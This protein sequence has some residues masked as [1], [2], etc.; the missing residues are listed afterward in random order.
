MI[1]AVMLWNEPNNN[2]HW[3]FESIPDGDLRRDDQAAARGGA[4]GEHRRGAGARRHIAHRPEV[5][6]RTCVARACSRRS[7]SSRCM[8]FR[9]IGTIG[10][11]ANGPRSCR[12]RPSP[13]CPLWVTEVGVSTFGAEEVQEFGLKR[14]AELLIARTAGFT[15]TACTTCRG[16]GPRR[17]VT[18]KPKGPP[19]TGISTWACLREDGTPKARLQTFPRI[20]AGPGHLPMVPL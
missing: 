16:P 9:S 5:R 13:I 7:K 14:T 1:E 19:I 15:G 4:R 17:R 10:R 2:S 8:A 6:C 12:S 11:S 3:D 18:G 20:H